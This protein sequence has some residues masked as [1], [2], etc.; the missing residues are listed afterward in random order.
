MLVLNH[1]TAAMFMPTVSLKTPWLCCHM[2]G[3]SQIRF[4]IGSDWYPYGAFTP[5]CG[6]ILPTSAS[7][8]EQIFAGLC[9]LALLVRV[10]MNA[11]ATKL[12][13]V[14]QRE[15][16][17]LVWCERSNILSVTVPPCH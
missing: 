8:R 17:L 9:L 4:L 13:K 6:D 7:N 10:N 3:Q 5:L 14:M 16:L 2:D 15:N 12:A 11:L 1:I